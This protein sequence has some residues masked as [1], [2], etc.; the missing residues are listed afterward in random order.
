[1][2]MNSYCTFCVHA[3][4]STFV[5]FTRLHEIDPI[6]LQ[7]KLI[8]INLCFLAMERKLRNNSKIQTNVYNL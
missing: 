1:M 5:I 7:T 2:N 8:R 3:E 4:G 6:Q